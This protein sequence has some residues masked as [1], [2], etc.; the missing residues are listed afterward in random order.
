MQPYTD[1]QLTMALALALALAEYGVA[2]IPD[3]RRIRV[4]RLAVVAAFTTCAVAPFFCRPSSP[5]R[6][7][8]LWSSRSAL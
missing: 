4:R 1:V 5:S 3:D 7:I 8:S 2:N 6:A